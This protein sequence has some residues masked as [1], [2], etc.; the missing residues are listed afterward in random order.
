MDSAMGKGVQVGPHRILKTSIRHF[1]E[2][3]S[4]I[5]KTDPERF[6]QLALRF[7]ETVNHSYIS[8]IIDSFRLTQPDKSPPEEKQKSCGPPG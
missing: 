8:A 6:G 3:L 4:K 5:A 7:P 1:S 2:G